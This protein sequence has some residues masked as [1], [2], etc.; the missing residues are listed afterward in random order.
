MESKIRI[1]ITIDEELAKRIDST[2]D[3]LKIRNRSHA[4]EY[5]LTKSLLSNKV[6]KAFILAGGKG[7]RLRPFT[8]EMPKSMIPVQGRPL[9]EHTIMNLRDQDVREIIISLG[10]MGGKIKEY[11]GNGSK[12][13]VNITYVEESEPLGTGGPLLLAKPYLNEQFLMINGD[14]LF[15]MDLQDLFKFHSK[16]GNMVTIALTTVADPS[17]YGVAEMKGSKIVT[18]IEKPKKGEAP[19]NLINAGVYVVDPSIFSILPEKG[20]FKIEVETFPKIAEMK[21]LGGY[22]FHGQWFPTD[23]QERY[24]E[25]IKGWNKK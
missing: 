18:F 8:Y 13:G 19:S 6:K 4:I 22:H 12:W 11:F 20:A 3:G 9:L 7:T 1:S 10:Y 25:A 17:S 15:D 16:N 5:L 21:R 24:E 2:V 14:N 23:N